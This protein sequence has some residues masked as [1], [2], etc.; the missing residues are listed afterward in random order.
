MKKKTLRVTLL[1][2]AFL[3]SGCGTTEVA[4]P[5]SS[6]SSSSN[7]DSSSSLAA[8]CV[9][10]LE[11]DSGIAVTDLNGDALKT[12]Y[13]LNAIVSFKV[14]YPKG[15]DVVVS[16]N[17]EILEEKDEGYS[18]VML[19]DSVL[20][21]SLRDCG[22]DSLTYHE[23]IEPSEYKVGSIAYYYCVNCES[24]F[25]DKEGTQKIENASGE[26][27]S[28]GDGR[29]LSP[30]KGEFS[31][32]SSNV[33]AYLNAKTDEEAIAALTNGATV[34][35]DQLTKTL[36]WEGASPAKY[37]VEISTDEN[38][39]SYKQY[40][41]LKNKL[42]LPGTLLPDT[43]YFWRVKDKNGEIIND[44][45]SFHTDD[46]ISVRSLRIDGGFNMRDLGGWNA[47][48]GNKVQYGKVYRGGRLSGLS[49][50]GKN[51]F[52]NELGI[53]TEI[54][55]R[56]S[57]TSELNVDGIEYFKAG[58]WQYTMIVPG[59]TS[60]A[61]SDNAS[62][63]RGYDSGSAASLKNIFEKLA[64]SSSYPVYFHCNAGADR[65]GTLAFLLNGLLGVSYSDLIKDFE[66]TTFSSQGARYRSA[67]DGSSFDSSGIMENSSGNLIAFGKMH[68]LIVANYP[69]KNGTL[70]AS[71]ERYLKEV[72]GLTEETIASVRKNMLG[73]D[74]AFDPIQLPD[75]E[76][77]TESDDFTIANSR[78]TPDTSNLTIAEETFEGKDSYKIVANDQGK[79]YFNLTEI[80]KYSKLS[81]NVYIPSGTPQMSGVGEFAIRWKRSSTD[82]GYLAYSST[83]SD[84]RK[85]TLDSWVSCN[86]DLSSFS[87]GLIEFAFII[88]KGATIHLANVKG[89]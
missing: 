4:S 79:I 11:L 66:L 59:Y 60:P 72:V 17:D 75:E 3:L 33:A 50:D 46:A 20:K 45:Y 54:D 67:I 6:E 7:A 57:G 8:K 68:D 27:I 58:M 51:V 85:I 12:S 16:L 48:G 87:S 42:A 15:K 78:L 10:T 34:Y 22:H 23:R 65:T 84:T 37:V 40:S 62:L 36:S 26:K 81:F 39:A 28:E 56:T 32:L 30:L 69:T 76:E 88:E 74:V 31:L 29:Y 64:D 49:E 47:E 21:I 53:K 19:S 82:K 1:S 43:T 73:E 71:I 5:F 14:T 25:F 18:F 24:S 13:D 41:V 83:S 38:F 61:A 52:A 89:L 55:L 86:E 77:Q 70:V 2:L 63:K 80:A 35:N 44:D 9:L